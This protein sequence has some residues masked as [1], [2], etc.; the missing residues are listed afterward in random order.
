MRSRLVQVAREPFGG[1]PRD[2]LQSPRLLEEVA[3]TG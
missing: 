2:L 3:C 1:E